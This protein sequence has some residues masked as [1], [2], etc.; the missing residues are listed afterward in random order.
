MDTRACIRIAEVPKHH[1]IRPEHPPERIQKRQGVADVAGGAPLTTG[2]SQAIV[3]RFEAKGAAPGAA[4]AAGI[5]LC[6]SPCVPLAIA[7]FPVRSAPATGIA[8]VGFPLVPALLSPAPDPLLLA[9]VD[10]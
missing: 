4:D 2:P 8:R 1:P 6:V 7:V 9:G 10:P 5:T 3:Q